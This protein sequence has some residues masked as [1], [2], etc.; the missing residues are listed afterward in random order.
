[1]IGWKSDDTGGVHRVESDAGP[2][3]D[4]LDQDRAAQHPAVAQPDHRQVGD[5][6]VAQRVPRHHAK[7]EKPWARAVLIVVLLQRLQHLRAVHEHDRRQRRKHSVTTAAPR[8]GQ[9]RANGRPLPAQQRV[10]QQQDA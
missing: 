5:H 2:V 4:G 10:D 7:A 1:M 6:G 3:E 9:R 8:G